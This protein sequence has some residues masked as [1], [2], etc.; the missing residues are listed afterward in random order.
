MART[1]YRVVE[2][3]ADTGF[4]T[5]APDLAGLF[6]N[7]ALALFDLMWETTPGEDDRMVNLTVSGGDLEELMVNFLEEFLYLLDTRQL[8]MNRIAIDT[9]EPQILT[10]KAW[11]HPVTAGRDQELLGV[12]AIT[13]HQLFVGH[14]DQGWRARVLLDI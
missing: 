4:E 12:K 10:G 3:P 6:Q 2:H 7:A 8:V 11:G 5:T 13:Y 9:I 1:F 14:T